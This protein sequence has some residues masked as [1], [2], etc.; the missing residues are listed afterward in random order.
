MI[1]RGDGHGVNGRA[2][3]REHLPE[4]DVKFGL[5]IFE[6]LARAVVAVGIAQGEDVFGG[7]TVG[8]HGALA[9]GADD[10]DI[11]FAVEVF[12]AHQRRESQGEGAGRQGGGLQE[13]APGLGALRWP[14]GRFHKMDN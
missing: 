14:Q 3:F 7:A 6:Q 13:L 10:G 9:A 11:K 4:V 12:T 2:E 8:V 1:R 5:G